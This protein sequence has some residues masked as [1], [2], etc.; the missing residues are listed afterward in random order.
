MPMVGTG[1]AAVISRARDSTVPSMTMAKAP[2]SATACAS[3]RMAADS[4]S[5]LPRAPYPPVVCSDWGRS[6]TW[7]STGMPRLVRKR[8]VSAISVP[9]SS[10]TPA[11][12]VCAMTRAQERNAA[13][14]D[15]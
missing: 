1:T 9:P 4:A 11:A 10:L 6:P 2:A 3:A 13:A 12:P 15:S 7:P 8:M 5:S 14:G